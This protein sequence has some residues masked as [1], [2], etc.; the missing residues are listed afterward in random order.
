LAAGQKAS[1]YLF[2][3]NPLAS[4]AGV[5]F[6]DV[7]DDG[8]QG[9]GEYGVGGVLITLRSLSGETLTTRTDDTGR[10]AFVNLLPGTYDIEE[11]QPDGFLDRGLVVGTGAR[12][13]G[14]VD[15]TSPNSMFAIELSFGDTAV[16]YTF[17]EHSTAPVPTPPSTT[18]PAATNPG[19]TSPTIDP[20]IARPPRVPARGL[21]TTGSDV[22]NILATAS[23]LV[24]LGATFFILGRRRRLR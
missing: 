19:P 14:T 8:V 7:D 10:Y 23:L 11:S 18:T 2:G 17:F 13:P 24:T 6:D 22:R 4:L 16:G 9:N 20:T 21:P 15:P 3:E 5:V 12:A 1:N